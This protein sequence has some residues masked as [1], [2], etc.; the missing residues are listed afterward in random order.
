MLWL[1]IPMYQNPKGPVRRNSGLVNMWRFR[2]MM[3][4]EMAWKLC[5]PYLIHFPMHLLHVAILALHP[6]LI[7]Q[8]SS[9]NVSLILWATLANQSNRWRR[10]LELPIYRLSVRSTDVNL[11]LCLQFEEGE[12][13]GEGGRE[14]CSL[15]GLM[16]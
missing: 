4:L 7:N 16:T 13:S 8:L 14:V 9:K 2:R 10:S 12:G 3:P 6:F 1:I 5:A 15:V 11:D